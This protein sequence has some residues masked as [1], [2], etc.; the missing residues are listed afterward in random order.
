MLTVT[1]GEIPRR[2]VLTWAEEGG[3]EG[4]GI[5][6]SGTEAW[7]S[8]EEKELKGSSIEAW[9]SVEGTELEGGRTEPWASAEFEGGSIEDWTTAEETEFEDGVTE[10]WTSGDWSWVDIRHHL[11][12]LLDILDN[13]VLSA[14]SCIIAGG[15]H[16]L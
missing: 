3:V 6:D 8:V 16:I 12:L 5:E 2:P 14:H 11:L 9:A 10:A 1:A 7:A 4:T 15:I 13:C